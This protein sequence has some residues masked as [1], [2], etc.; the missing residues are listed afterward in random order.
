MHKDLYA[1]G[2][3]YNKS[4]QQILLRQHTSAPFVWSLFG[5]K[6][7]NGEDPAATFGRIIQEQL[8]TKTT[9]NPIYDYFD[10]ELNA[11]CHVFYGQ[12]NTTKKISSDQKNIRWFTFKEILKLP[13]D[14]Q[15]KQNITIG[16]RVIE[17]I[18]RNDELSE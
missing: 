1:S 2:F 16:R 13:I 3:L 6:T 10:K 7:Q 8:G 17:A 4:T 15:A 12:I 9:V 14:K 18:A 11:Q 5:G